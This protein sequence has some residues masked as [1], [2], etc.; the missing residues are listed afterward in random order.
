L[1]KIKGLEKNA[2]V[3]VLGIIKESGKITD[4]VPKN[5]SEK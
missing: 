3:D 1:I 2:N 4:F 5:K